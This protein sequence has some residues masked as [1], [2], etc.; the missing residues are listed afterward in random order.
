MNK[1]TKVAKMY[2]GLIEVQRQLT[3]EVLPLMYHLGFGMTKLAGELDSTVAS[4]LAF[5]EQHELT[6]TKRKD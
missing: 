1:S 5:A 4:I 6:I 2:L 3:D